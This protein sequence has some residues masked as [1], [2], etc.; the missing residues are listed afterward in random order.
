LPQNGRLPDF[1]RCVID[2]HFLLLPSEKSLHE[3]VPE[4]DR[5]RIFQRW[6][7]NLASR[8]LPITLPRQNSE[9]ARS[10]DKRIANNVWL[11]PVKVRRKQTDKSAL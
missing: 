2:F 11:K 10:L 6:S 1:G 9:I 5:I 7:G 4:S 8:L 3:T